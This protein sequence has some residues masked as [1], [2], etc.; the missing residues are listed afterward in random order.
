MILEDEPE[1]R[2]LK[3]KRVGELYNFRCKVIHGK[4]E[5]FNLLSHIEDFDLSTGTPE[6]IGENTKRLYESYELLS[7]LLMKVLE[8]GDFWTREEL[9]KLQNDFPV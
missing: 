2:K 1:K 8:R 9:R 3:S 6:I 4:A 5:D 7:Q